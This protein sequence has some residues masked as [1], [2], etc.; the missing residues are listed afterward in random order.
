[1]SDSKDGYTFQPSP[2]VKTADL[3]QW[4]K[5]AY[6]MQP[7][8]GPGSGGFKQD[9]LD[10]QTANNDAQWLRRFNITVYKPGE[11]TSSSQQKTYGQGS[12]PGLDLS[13]LRCTFN[14]NK[15]TLM[16]PN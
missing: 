9:K 11:G 16:T 1:M 14:I 2:N 15:D 13:A 10:P 4:R 7:S 3:E 6:Q 8:E 5:L 12:T